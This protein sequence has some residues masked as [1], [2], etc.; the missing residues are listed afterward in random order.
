MAVVTPLAN[1]INAACVTSIEGLRVK[2]LVAFWEV[3]P[4]CG[5]DQD[6]GR[7]L[8]MLELLLGSRQFHDVAGGVLERDKFAAIGQRDRII[9]A[10]GP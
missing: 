7:S 6:V 8:P 2:A 1:A 4:L 10:V 9:E 5:L 3:A